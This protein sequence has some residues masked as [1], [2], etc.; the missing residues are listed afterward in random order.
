MTA[1]GDD[2]QD[3]AE[4]TEEHFTAIQQL[5]LGLIFRCPRRIER[6]ESNLMT[7]AYLAING[8]PVIG[9][10]DSLTNT[11]KSSIID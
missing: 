10:L 9:K 1:S 7:L 11:Q 2:P 8:L 6:S 4:L 5:F 3:G